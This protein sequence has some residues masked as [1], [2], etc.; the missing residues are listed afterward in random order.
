MGLLD[1]VKGLI[2]KNS[3]KVDTGIEKAGDTIDKKTEGKYS[4]QVDKAEDAAQKFVSQLDD[5]PKPAD[6]AAPAAPTPP[7]EATSGPPPPA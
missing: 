1:K 5:S 3:D 6:G 4:G 7:P 2:S